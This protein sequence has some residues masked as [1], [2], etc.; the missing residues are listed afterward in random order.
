MRSRSDYEFAAGIV[1]AI[2]T[3]GWT[4]DPPTWADNTRFVTTDMLIDNNIDTAYTR[5]VQTAEAFI[6]FFQS[7]DALFDVRSFL[8]A[9]GLAE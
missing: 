8:V 5:A 1:S 2:R 4:P 6:L 7:G 9:C 3:G